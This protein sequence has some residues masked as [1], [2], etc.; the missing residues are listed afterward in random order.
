MMLLTLVENAIK[1]GLNPLAEGGFVRLRAER[2]GA[3][4]HLEVADNGR[5]LAAGEGHGTGLS[6]VR[7]R[8]ALL[9]GTRAALDV[10]P[11]EPRGFV[12]KVSLPL[13]EGAT[14]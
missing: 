2:R 11:G 4:L 5:G 1:H 6:N 10:A 12:A 8:L 14:A 7:A 13:L 9:Y 3:E